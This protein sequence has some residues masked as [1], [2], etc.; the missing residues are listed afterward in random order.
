MGQQACCANKDVKDTDALDPQPQQV[1][2]A[3]W[4]ERA[5]S[6]SDRGKL[7]AAT[8]QPSTTTAAAAPTDRSCTLE[9]HSATLLRSFAKIGGMDPYVVVRT[10]GL[11]T[12][13]VEIFRSEPHK[14]GNKEPKWN[15][16]VL[17]GEIP[18]NVCIDVWDKNHFHKDV[19]CG[20][21]TIPC[22]ADMGLDNHE[23]TLEK[24]TSATGSVC[25][26]F[27]SDTSRQAE[28]RK[29][30]ETNP[31]L[32]GEMDEMLDSVSRKDKSHKTKTIS[33]QREQ[34]PEH[35]GEHEDDGGAADVGPPITREASKPSAAFPAHALMGSW[36]CVA[37]HGLEDFLVAS[38]A[39]MFQRKI[40]NAAKWPAWDFAAKDDDIVFINHSA[41]GDI[42][43]EFPIGKV[44]DWV[45][46]KSNKWKCDAKWTTSGDGGTLT[47]TRKGVQGDYTEERQVTGDELK[48]TLSNPSVG[49]S[50]GRTFKRD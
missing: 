29:R 50:W 35:E 6:E 4:T 31:S 18:E 34:L 38:G 10:K 19:F 20:S 46:G 15:Q 26:T 28:T 36:T 42:R 43:E 33:L 23:F 24:R 45:D 40:A 13:P 27:H 25:V 39:G 44:Y 5:V 41:I 1:L 14:G 37:T 3:P 8:P 21:V 7:Q 9:I 12:A 32:G 30:T 48:F 49:C 11:N 22:S 2:E 47:H 17:L 16:S